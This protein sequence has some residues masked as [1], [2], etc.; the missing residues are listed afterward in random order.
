[1]CVVDEIGV[2]GRVL[3]SALAI[4]GAAYL[5]TALG[6]PRF[7]LDTMSVN[8]IRERHARSPRMRAELKSW[9]RTPSD[10]PRAPWWEAPLNWFTLIAVAVL[11]YSATYALIAAVPFSWGGY[12]EDGE[13]S[14]ARTTLQFT[15]A[16]IGALFLM[17]RLE[18]VA[19]V[20][21]CE[22]LEKAARKHILDGIRY[23]SGISAETRSDIRARLEKELG[24]DPERYHDAEA[25]RADRL[26]LEVLAKLPKVDLR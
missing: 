5:T 1:M 20:L 24:R 9:G 23:A 18:K 2:V 14:S 6:A 10:W 13:W 12:D 8:T 25:E 3:Q 4:Y 21:V 22:P 17:E 11:A 19:E 16:T 15:G 26:R 7:F